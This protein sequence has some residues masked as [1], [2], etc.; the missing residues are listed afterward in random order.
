MVLGL[1]YADRTL[2][3]N[4]LPTILESVSTS[5]P[6]LRDERLRRLSP[7]RHSSFTSG[8]S[9][10]LKIAARLFLKPTTSTISGV[11]T[12][13]LYGSGGGSGGH[14]SQALIIMAH[15]TAAISR[16]ARHCLIEILLR[17]NDNEFAWK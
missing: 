2:G 1:A 8:W 6:S 9:T 3:V 13:V 15:T 16:T 7:G 10:T 4:C 14:G 11:A 5:R 12:L 17:A